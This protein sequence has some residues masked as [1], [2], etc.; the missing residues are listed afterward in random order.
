MMPVVC[1]NIADISQTRRCFGSSI[2]VLLLMASPTAAQVSR[3]TTEAVEDVEAVLGG[4][5]TET[6]DPTQ[7]IEALTELALNPLDINVASA[8]ELA[9]I[10]ALGPV[11]AQSIVAF[12]VAFGAFRSISEMRAIEGMTEDAF[13]D[14]RLYLTIDETLAVTQREQARFPASPSVEQMVDGLRFEAIQR[15]GRRLDLGRGY[16]NNTTRTTYAGSPDRLYTRLRLRSRRTVSL[17]VTLEKDPGER[18]DWDP[19][20]ATFGYDYL[21]AHAA[22]QDYGRIK[23]LVIGDYVANY[24]QGVALWRS[25]AF[26]KGREPV[27]PLVRFGNGIIPYGSTD[28]NSFLRGIAATVRITPGLATSVFASRH[29]LDAGFVKSDTTTDH[30]F[31]DLTQATALS[32]SG[33]HRTASEIAGKDAVRETLVGGGLEYQR[34]TAKLGLVGYHSQFNRAFQPGDQPYQR[35]RFSGTEATVASVYASASV[36]NI[37]L[38]GEVAR[39]PEGIFGGIGGVMM[40]FSHAAEAVILARHYPRNFVSLHGYGLGE[41][42]GAT[43]NETG[44]YMGVQV[45]AAPQWK[46]SFY[47]DQYR[48]PW[49][50]FSVPLPSSGYEALAV[51]EHRPRR[52]LT[53]YLQGRTETKEAGTQIA[54]EHGRLLD[55]VQPETRQSLR[56][57]SDY[58]FSRRLRLRARGEVIRFS[59]PNQDEEYGLLLYQDIRWL[60]A[61]RL[62]I[63]LRIAFFDSDSFD[64]RVF[65]YENDLIYTLSVPAFSGQ[66]QRTY[67]LMRWA[68]MD[69]LTFQ[70]KYA[71]TYYEN[72][73]TVG[74]GLNEVVG[75]RLREIRAQI[76][77]RF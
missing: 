13:L 26:G 59:A 19:E 9:Q 15:F 76:Q 21:S 51:V 72:V 10:P 32:L 22:L 3:D 37:H 74:S 11:L 43:Q 75:Q 62:Q 16:D 25:S 5:E 24:G 42:N 41:R 47:F 40:R 14:A 34:A 39:A 58:Q 38:F 77:L 33:L 36:H 65:M 68:P 17:N 56:L 50:R 20:T 30:P 23:A 18:F 70:A 73:Q 60:P 48:F 53:V 71:A 64:A 29:A 4:L 61:K 46:A 57:H 31:E 35:F 1:L 45:Q 55:A 12:R 54:D 2:L 27:R 6:G 52:W 49:A 69:I 44:Y 63:D 66:G 7:L 67:I 8:E 28:E